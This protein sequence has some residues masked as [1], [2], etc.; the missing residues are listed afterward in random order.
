[1]AKQRV[2]KADMLVIKSQLPGGESQPLAVSLQEGVDFYTLAIVDLVAEITVSGDW[3]PTREQ[4]ER[5]LDL[6]NGRSKLIKEMISA[7]VDVA[8]TKQMQRDYELEGKIMVDTMTNVLDVVLRLALPDDPRRVA[9]LDVWA[10][11]S[12]IARL[13]GVPEPTPPPTPPPLPAAIESSETVDAVVVDDA[14]INYSP[15]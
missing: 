1:M 14:E 12:M 2:G 4:Q 5:L 11:T 3:A 6:G 9:E 15:S 8:I 13:H 7:G 10:R